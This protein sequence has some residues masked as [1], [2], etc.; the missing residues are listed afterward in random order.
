MQNLHTVN[1]ALGES[2]DIILYS[3]VSVIFLC[4]LTAEYLGTDNTAGLRAA[5]FFIFFVSSTS[6]LPI[7]CTQQT[8]TKV[9]ILMVV[10]R[11]CETIRLPRG[12]CCKGL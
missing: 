3:T 11:R 6:S 8:H 5:V 7:D 10:L 12:E 9:H 2:V 1:G 4:V